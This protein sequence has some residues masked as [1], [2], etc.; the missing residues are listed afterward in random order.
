M[1]L[2]KS[3]V[4][5]SFACSAV[6]YN[7]EILLLLKFSASCVVITLAKACACAC[8]SAEDAI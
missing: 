3:V 4:M 5:Y 2:D 6:E 1:P 8:S 7:T